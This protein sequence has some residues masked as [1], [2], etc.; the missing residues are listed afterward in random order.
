M[1][2][3]DGIPATLYQV[4][5]RHSTRGVLGSAMR[6][7]IECNPQCYWEALKAAVASEFFSR[8]YVV[9]VQQEC[10]QD[11]VAAN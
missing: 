5:A 3:M 1:R 6:E 10:G 9:A 2:D 11:I 7:Y 8:D 4:I